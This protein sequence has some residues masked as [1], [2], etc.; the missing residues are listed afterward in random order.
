MR[1]KINGEDQNVDMNMGCGGCLLQIAIWFWI[2][3]III[4]LIFKFL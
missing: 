4:I 1:M 3:I 2:P